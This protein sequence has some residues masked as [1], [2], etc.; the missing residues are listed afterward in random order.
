MSRI[1]D[2][3]YAMTRPEVV[4]LVQRALDTETDE[5]KKAAYQQYLIAS[6]IV[7]RR[8]KDEDHRNPV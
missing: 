4:E 1:I 7:V 6:E 3:L 5:D 8:D 2:A